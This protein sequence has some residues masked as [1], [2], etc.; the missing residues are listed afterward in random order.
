MFWKNKN[1]Y[2][3]CNKSVQYI[4]MY[5]SSKYTYY[6]TF[7]RFKNESYWYKLKI[8]TLMGLCDLLLR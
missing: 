6:V 7:F 8:S 3:L 5:L 2:L 4:Y 1:D